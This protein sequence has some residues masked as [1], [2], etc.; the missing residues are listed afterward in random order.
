MRIESAIVTNFRC[1]VDSGPF[2]VARDKTILV[3]INEAGKTAL[4]RAIQRV[5]PPTDSQSIDWLF[6][7]PAEMVDDIRRGNLTKDSLPVSVVTLVPDDADLAGLQLP[8]D[9][10]EI[11]LEVTAWLDNRRTSRVVGLPDHPTIGEADASL[12]RLVAAMSQ[13]SSAEAKSA[14][15]GLSAWRDQHQPTTPIAGT[16]RSDLKSHLDATL[17][18]FA[19]GSAAETHW[20]ALQLLH[21]RGAALD[22]IHTHLM[23]RLP[24]F[25]YY[26]SYFSVRPK[27][28]LDRLA[29]REENGEIDLDY[30]FGNLQLL[31]FLGFTARELSDMDSQAPQKPEDYDSSVPARE[32]YAAAIQVHERRITERKRALQTASAKL[33]QEIRRVWNDDTLTLRLDVDG[34][35]LQ[36]LVEDELGVP[37]ELDQRS[38]G[39]RWLVSFF[40]VFHAQAS[41]SLRNAVLLLDEPGLSLHALKQQEFRKTVSRLA[42]GNQIVYTTH[43]PFMVGADELDLVRVVEMVDRRTGTKVHTRLAVDDPKSIYPLQA[44]LGY[45]LAQSMFT[46]KKNLV[47]EGVTDLLYVEALNDLSSAEGGPVLLDDV[48]IVPAGSASK[49]IYYSTVLT[50]QSL[51]VA[52]LLDSDAAGDQAAEQEEL[53]QLLGQK[54]IL[55]TG[56]FVSPAVKRAEIEDLLRFTLTEV[57]KTE[58]GWDSEATINAQPTRPIV[59]ILTA[60]HSAFSKWKLAR[61][62][63]RWLARSGPSPLN[64]RETSAWANFVEAA[65]KALS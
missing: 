27:I 63:V 24:V 12:S 13:Q 41:D 48:A 14:A 23:S 62:F 9:T 1:V 50:S 57:A 61:A 44:A 42:E 45:N 51:D 38:E 55:R 8:G 30:D 39:F 20:K 56:D 22:K 3:G 26:S 16:I 54:R 49:V 29:E 60:E 25:V 58:C 34:Q 6:D 53:W 64:R 47:V 2:E 28:H 52:A 21:S 43:S 37:V 19:E 32:E 31:K 65:N 35:Y 5:S 15:R 7:A 10:D 46:H 59:E 36:T 40:V 11:R 33:T 17:P 18:Q 4:L